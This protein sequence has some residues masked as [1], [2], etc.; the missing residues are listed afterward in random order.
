MTFIRVRL[1]VVALVVFPLMASA[2]EDRPIVARVQI[3]G[4]RSV[5][6]RDVQGWL[7]TRAGVAVDSALL[8]KDV[9]R[10]LEEYKKQGFWRVAVSF[11]KIVRGDKTTVVFAIA[12]GARTRV[13][14][15]QV[16]GELIFEPSDVHATLGMAPGMVLTESDL[17]RHLDRLLRFYEDR[18]YPFCALRPDVQWGENGAGVRVDVS[19]GP[20]VRIDTVRFE[21]NEVTRDDVLLRH[22]SVGEVYDQRRVDAFVQGLQNL[23]FIDRVHK[24][25]LVP[26]GQ[27]MALVIGL[28]ESRHTRI[29]GGLGLGSGQTLTGAIALDVLNFSGGGREGD[30]LWSR[31]DE[32]AS[33]LR[34]SYREPYVFNSAISAW[35]RVEMHERAG[36]VT[37]RFGAG[38]DVSVSASTH[39]FGGIAHSRVLPDSTGLGFYDAEKMW[40]LETGVRIDRRVGETRGWQ[41]EFKGEIGEVAPGIRRVRWATDGQVS[42]PLGRQF[43]I[44]GRARVSWVGQT[45][46]VPE[47][48]WIWLGGTQT[49]RGYREEQFGGTTAGWVNVEC[50]RLLGPK[51]RV[52]AFV[53]A[54]RISNAETRHYPLSYGMGL[55]ATSR[56]GTLGIDYGLP[57]KESL[58]QGMV[59]VRMIRA[60]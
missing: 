29:E 23:P 19:P 60:F 28:E 51:T 7:V 48:A 18:G 13:A 56:M 37:Q 20:L 45:R 21:G 55:L 54:G 31:R 24:A 35:G 27:E 33:H 42:W 47:T 8:R 58:D 46:G 49:L 15:V 40:S 16:R 10:I 6:V 30:A 43:A 2:E 1:S 25:E 50:R 26:T 36:Y 5:P 11:P 52:F 39:L 38:A 12:E 4:A 34:V 41:A 3:E 14:S 9:Q 53:D 57:W 22:I 59:H 44:A 17:N 32:G